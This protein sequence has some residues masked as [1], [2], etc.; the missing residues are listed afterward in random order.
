MTLEVFSNLNDS[1]ILWCCPESSSKRSFF[2][3]LQRSQRLLLSLYFK[4]IPMEKARFAKIWGFPCARA[5]RGCSMQF[6]RLRPSQRP[7]LK[8]ALDLDGAV[9]IVALSDCK[10]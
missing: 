2:P 6:R 8:S 1:V 10:W 3:P 7:W 9:E 4:A 5:A